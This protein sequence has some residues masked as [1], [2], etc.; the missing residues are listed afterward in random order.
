IKKF[1]EKEKTPPGLG[2]VASSQEANLP[3]IAHPHNAQVLCLRFLMNKIR[4]DD[5]DD[6][7][8]DCDDG[9]GDGDDGGGD[10]DDDGD[11]GGDD[12]GDEDGDDGG[13]EDG[14]DG[15]DGGDDGD[16]GGDDGDD[17]GGGDG[18]DG[19]DDG[20]GD[21]DDGGDDGC[22]DGDDDGDDGDNDGDDD[23][24]GGGDGDDGGGDGDDGD[25]DGDDDG[26]DGGGDDGTQGHPQQGQYLRPRSDAALLV[27]LFLHQMPFGVQSH[28]AGTQPS[29]LIH[30]YQVNFAKFQGTQRTILTPLLQPDFA[31]CSVRPR[32]TLAWH[33]SI[34][35]GARGTGAVLYVMYLAL[36]N[37]DGS[38]NR[39]NN[40]EPWHNWSEEGRLCFQV[41]VSHMPL[42]DHR[43]LRNAVLTTCA[44]QIPGLK[45]I[46]RLL[47]VWRLP[48]S[49]SPCT[50]EALYVVAI[51]LWLELDATVKHGGGLQQ[52]R[53]A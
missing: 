1:P 33:P 36:F 32:S 5:D 30:V 4:D 52:L 44:L 17:D 37:P 50:L 35:T 15:G 25:N 47:L 38:W 42:A 13:D 41:R 39:K 46:I 23:G 22:S 2:H 6:G 31:R 48:G 26:D 24:G 9:G 16:D 43:G 27:S 45:L 8:G 20:C 21:G 18:D 34:L 40:P 7:G 29:V 11:D 28:E 10:G 3:L 19:D 51:R 53:D 49:T 14:D 12:G